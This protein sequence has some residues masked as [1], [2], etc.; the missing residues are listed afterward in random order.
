MIYPAINPYV[1]I[2][3]QA[4]VAIDTTT[5]RNVE[6]PKGAYPILRL[7]DGKTDIDTIVEKLWGRMSFHKRAFTIFLTTCRK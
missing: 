1:V 3:E 5:G 6:L 7:V 2:S 4:G